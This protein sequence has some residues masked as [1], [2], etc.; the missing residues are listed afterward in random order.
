MPNA[1]S[2]PLSKH[3]RQP[4][5]YLKLPSEGKFWPRESLNLPSTGD[6]PVYPMTVK[7]EITL[8]TPDALMNGSGVAEV[9]ES[10]CP[11]IKNA[12]DVP[13]VDLDAI[14]I[15]I[16]LASYGEGMDLSTTCPSCKEENEFTVDLRVLLDSIRSAD[17]NPV[18][19]NNLEFRFRPQTFKAL[20]E[21]NM[22]S[23]EQQ[24]LVD[25]IS[26]SDLSPDEKSAH[27]KTAFEKLTD[28]NI[29]ALVN[30]IESIKLEDGTIVENRGHL[31]EFISNCERRVYDNIKD[32]VAAEAAKVKL[33]PI[34]LSCTSCNHQYNTELNFDQAN[35]FG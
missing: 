11:N 24:K 6:I 25:A 28:M 30:S 3:F 14:L 5:V 26:N 4:A 19:I 12:W 16:R 34:A 2:N 10:C 13:T 1:S 33:D 27:V 21:I 23:F 17:Y 7:D 20:N 18:S 31:K 9:I 22:I 32:L 8:K 29:M 15:A 35:F